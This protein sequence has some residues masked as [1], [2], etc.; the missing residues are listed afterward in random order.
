MAR[1]YQHT[2]I[3]YVLISVLAV[4]MIMIMYLSILY[5]FSW[6]SLLVLVAL[7]ICLA[8]FHSLT[9]TVDGEMLE[10]KF[11]VGFI[12]KK[13]LLRDVLAAKAVKNPWYY[14][15]GIRLTPHGWLYNVSVLHAV[16]IELKNGKKYRIGTDVPENLEKAIREFF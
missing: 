8:L 1:V 16:E 3:G 15:W 9:I 13:F 11:G 12:R 5:G 14:G 2:Q 4:S 10:M 7:A 6:V